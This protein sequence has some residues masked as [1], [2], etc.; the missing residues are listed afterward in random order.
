MKKLLKWI[1]WIVLSLIILL[2]IAGV[3]ITKLVN[4]NDYKPQIIAAVNKA[5]GRSLSLPGNLSWTFFPNLGIHIGQASLSNPSTYAAPVFAQVQSADISIAVLPLLSGQLQANTLE[6]QGLQLNLERKTLADN[7]WTFPAS[8]NTNKAASGS[9]ISNSNATEMAFVPVISNL[10]IKNAN[11]SFIDDTSGAH[12]KLNNVNFTGRHIGLDSPFWIKLSF[13]AESNQP[14]MTAN[15]SMKAELYADLINQVY[16]LD[17]IDAHSTVTMPRAAAQALQVDADISGSAVVDLH[18]DTL[19]ASPSVVINNKLNFTGNLSVA[20]LLG[21]MSYTGQIQVSPFDLGQLMNS[22]GMKAPHFPSAQALSNVSMQGQFSGTKQSINFSK[23]ALTLNQSTLQGQF[24]IV[25]FTVSAISIQASMDKMDLS[26]YVDMKGT[27]LPIQNVNLQAQLQA[28]GW[29]K[30]Q[31][32]SSLNG[33]LS[34]SVQQIT[35]KGL[36]LNEIFNSLNNTIS[37]LGSG[38]SLQNQINSLQ[39]QFSGKNSINANNGKQTSLGSLNL[40]AKIQNGL[41]TTSQFSLKGPT[42][43]VQ[44]S[45]NANLNKQNMSFLFYI[46]N[47][48][49]KPS[50]TLPYRVSGPFNDPSQGVDWILFQTELQK[51]LA[52][53]LQQSVQNGVKGTVNTLLNQLVNSVNQQ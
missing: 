14:Q 4:P 21:N 40:Q 8:T 12:Y 19:I 11:I 3:V 2:I 49:Q 30:A 25:N 6:L 31:F 5:T 38:Q 51:Y 20:Q 34:I 42:I 22:M 15:I 9:S 47:P 23:L 33:Q 50:L 39:Q 10:L 35:L 45:G 18:K 13:V 32:P 48:S 27:G 53:A 36:D 41:L 16:R 52:Q 29:N 1:A 7:N 46:N 43:Q 24:A 17:A 37:N 28:R 26:D 44:G